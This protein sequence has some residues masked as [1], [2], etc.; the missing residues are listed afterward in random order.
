MKFFRQA[1]IEDV[2]LWLPGALRC[3]ESSPFDEVLNLAIALSLLDDL[4]DSIN[5][6]VNSNIVRGCS[7]FRV[8]NISLTVIFIVIVRRGTIVRDGVWGRV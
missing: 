5:I 4:F 1:N 6:R 8:K 3:R 7:D 2:L